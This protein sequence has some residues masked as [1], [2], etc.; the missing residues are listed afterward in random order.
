MSGS[1]WAVIAGTAAVTALIKGAGPAALGG[2]E[3]PAWFSGVVR[4]LAPALLAAL[5]VTNAFADGEELHVGAD[6][7]GVLAATGVLLRGA[8]IIV[9][10]V[11]AAGTTAALRAIA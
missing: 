10:V 4:L 2:R 7:V 6:T 11:V 9:A 8:S 5:V 1:T 3:L